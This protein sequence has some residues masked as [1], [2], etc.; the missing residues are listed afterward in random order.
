[1]HA[2]MQGEPLLESVK[3]T[4]I[5]W[6]PKKNLCEKTVKQKSGKP[7]GRNAQP[8]RVTVKVKKVRV[9][10]HHFSV[11]YITKHIKRLMFKAC[12]YIAFSLS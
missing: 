7:R 11:A 2:C 6:H 10:E 1:M 9:H 5:Q 4:D 12:T 8:Q 3:G